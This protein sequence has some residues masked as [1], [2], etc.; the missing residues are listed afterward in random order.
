MRSERPVS[1]AEDAGETFTSAA[2]RAQFVAAAIDTIAEVGYAHA[3]L[4][5]I[6][7]RVGVSKGVISYHFAGKDELVREVIAG[8]V[9]KGGEFI[10]ER[11]MTEATAPGRLRAWIESN[12]EFMAAHRR[13]MMAFFE[14]MVGSRGDAAVSAAVA[15]LNTGAAAGIQDMLAAGQASGE[16]RADFDPQAVATAI[17]AIVDAVPPRMVRDP[18]FDVARYG[19]EIAGLFDAATRGAAPRTRSR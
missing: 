16:L 15:E 4:G 12:L 11:P 13:E 14:I 3:S 8:V 2:R 9:A 18:G 10:C 17:M 7:E 1:R 19:R 5:R 6:A